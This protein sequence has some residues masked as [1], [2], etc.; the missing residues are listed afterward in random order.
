MVDG[1]VRLDAYR[2]ADAGDLFVALDDVR[3]WEHIPRDVPDGP[4]QLHDAIRSRLE[5]GTRA[6]FVV[7]DGGRIVGMTSVVFDPSDPDGAEIGGTQLSPETWGTGVNG[8][9][10]RLL[11]RTLFVA[12]A[13]WVQFR[14]DERN[15]RSAAAIRK[16]GAVDLG[17]RDD[18]LVRR[19]GTVRRSRFFRLQNPAT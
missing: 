12:G 9:A 3:A 14:T 5:D 1:A 13:S 7:R 6:T 11:I 18:T 10:K 16:L 8:I 4:E 15:L 19:D 2:A 17:V